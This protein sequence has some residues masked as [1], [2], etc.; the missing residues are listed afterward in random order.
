M[1]SNVVD[2]LQKSLRILQVLTLNGALGEYGGPNRV[3]MELAMGLKKRGH[4]VQIFTGVIANSIP[5]R[6][7]ELDEVHEVVKPLFNSFP[8]S[9]LWSR[10]L[11][12][13]LFGLIKSADIIHIHF[14][15]DLIPVLAAFICILLGKPFITQTHG[16]VV[17]DNRITT[18][19][20]DVLFTRFLINN[21]AMNLVLSEQEYANVNAFDF[22]SQLQ[23]LP[24]GIR[25]TNENMAR[26]E[27]KIPKIVYCSRLHIRKRPDRFLN[28]ARFAERN[29]LD[30]DFV[31]FGP[32]GGELSEITQEIQSDIDLSSVLYEGALPPSQVLGMLRTC[33]LLVLP[34]ENEPFPM[35]VLEALSVGT[36]VLIMPSCGLSSFLRDVYPDM[37]VS[38][39]S[40]EALISAFTR[41]FKDLPKFEDRCGIRSFCKE[42]FDID[43]VTSELEIYYF[44]LVNR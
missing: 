26:I 18:R 32:D 2:S 5:E 20:F 44:A 36:P 1:D 29:G 41:I 31:I 33:D 14:A 15:R 7:V 40:E 35:V 30:A 24:N 11:P 8:V 25:V 23:I 4:E 27:N 9:S 10:R 34:S 6:N 22:K 37:V 42:I 21:S 43:K 16:M 19:I 12:R 13:K 17:R 3:A 38:E 39:E 28:L